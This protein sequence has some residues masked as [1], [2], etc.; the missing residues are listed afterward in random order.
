M[1]YVYE[2]A[3]LE[4]ELDAAT[5]EET[6][7]A[8]LRNIGVLSRTFRDPKIYGRRLF[9]TGLDALVPKVARRLNL[10]DVTLAKSNDNVCIV[11]TEFFRT[12]GH[13]R[14]ALDIIE[15]FPQERRPVVFG[16]KIYS[17]YSY[18]S[19][20]QHPE[21]NS[22]MGERASVGLTS[23]T[24]VGK[25][26]ELYMI[27]LVMRPT[28][29]FLMAHPMDLVAVLATWPFRSIVDFL[30]H[31]DHVP[32]IG[33]TLP[34]SSHVDVTYTCHLACREAGFDAIYSGMSAR[35]A[36]APASERHEGKSLRIA[37]CGSSHKY[38]GA[39]RY[40]WL[41]YAVAALN[42]PGS[43]LIHIGPTKP[44]FEA[45]IRNALASA[46]IAPER[47]VFAGWAASLG[48][49]LVKREVDVYLSSFPETGGKANLEAMGV[50]VPV[51]IPMGADMP[52]LTR[53][54]LPLNHWLE[55]DRPDELAEALDKARALSR[56]MREPAEVARLEAELSRF[57]DYV[58]LRPVSRPAVS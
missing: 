6:L 18:T 57:D 38:E 51:I 35:R 55:I 16:T 26:V 17:N 20:L 1:K 10:R 49:E 13:S 47:Y 45:E 48:E 52:P 37:T 4:R 34:F 12:G 39:R 36:E 24:L 50:G 19:L 22:G 54:N 33:A 31:A 11:G 53:F 44:E 41:D 28:R 32:S 30:H 58:A 46:G 2:Q 8:A 9:S 25:I 29:I 43:E 42:A 21:L 23:P 27:L 40:R 56:A 5:T 3:T 15:R 14:V 7:E